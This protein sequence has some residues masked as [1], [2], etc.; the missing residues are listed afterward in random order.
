MKLATTLASLTAAVT[1]GAPAWAIPIAT[2]GSA[3]T[4]VFSAAVQPPSDANEISLL[5]CAYLGCNPAETTLFKND[6]VAFEAVIDGGV[7]VGYAAQFGPGVAPSLFSIK[8]GGTSTQYLFENNDSKL[9]A[10][11]ETSWFIDNGIVSPGSGN[12]NPGRISHVSWID[13]ATTVSEPAT[14]ALLGL[15]L[16]GMAG[17][18]RVRR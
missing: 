2:V 16:L 3:D 5:F 14:L 18:R 7:T 1:L 11:I 6:A 17:S 12:A 15:A 9:W 10:F 4:Q 8:L 13:S